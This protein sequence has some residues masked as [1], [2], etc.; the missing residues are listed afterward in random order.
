MLVLKYIRTRGY[1]MAR[2]QQC[3]QKYTY[4]PIFLFIIC[5]CFWPIH[6]SEIASQR[7]AR[8]IAEQKNLQESLLTYTPLSEALIVLIARYLY[9]LSKNR[10][11]ELISI[12]S[13][14]YANEDPHDTALDKKKLKALDPDELTQPLANN[15]R[16][17]LYLLAKKYFKALADGN[18]L[19][20]TI[21]PIIESTI[22]HY[23]QVVN[24]SNEKNQTLYHL[25]AKKSVLKGIIHHTLFDI[26][27]H[28]K[29]TRWDQK[30]HVGSNCLML[31]MNN[32]DVK[33]NADE[34]RAKKDKALLRLMAVYCKINAR[35]RRNY[36][37]L[38]YALDNDADDEIIYFLVSHLKANPHMLCGT[39]APETSLKLA[40]KKQRS[41]ELIEFLK[42]QP[43]SI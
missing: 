9:G 6:A 2:D 29:Q 16:T 24:I 13:E 39:I 1:A 36:T 20:S 15:M 3:K 41:H 8:L 25:A 43:H 40:Q 12:I 23:P 17:G 27:I 37:I 26:L 4:Y 22:K 33:F 18:N 42:M 11:Q 10:Q 28:N 38:H 32:Q 19:H 31:F 30:D 7:A 21:A 34:Q 35:D 14:I 5:C